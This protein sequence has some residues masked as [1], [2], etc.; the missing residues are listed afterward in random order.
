MSKNKHNPFLLLYD[1]TNDA[2]LL[3]VLGYN[4]ENNGIYHIPC[5]FKIAFNLRAYSTRSYFIP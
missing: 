3:K 2:G 1:L 4:I 5:S